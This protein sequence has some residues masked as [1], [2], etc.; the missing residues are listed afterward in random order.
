VARC[1]IIGCGCRGRALGLELQAQ[2][3]AVRGST[4]RPSELAAIEA[5][6]IEAHLGDPDRV[7]TLAPAF[8][9]VTI[10]CVLLGSAGGDPE[11]LRA[12]H[13]ARLEML[14]TRMLDTTIRGLVY[15][16]A[17]GVNPDVLSSGSG[18]V[19]RLCRDS[20]IPYAV[21][22]R[23]PDEHSAWRREALSA[24]Q[25]LLAPAA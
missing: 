14:L 17:G 11:Q 12:L 9:H 21:L 2:G 13:G 22:S 6:G 1:L 19:R 24:V 20:L 3:H 23:A 25:Q 16:A 4:R 8:E 7:A 5:A 10:A 18:I 15:E